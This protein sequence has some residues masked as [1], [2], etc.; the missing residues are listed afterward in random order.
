MHYFTSYNLEVYA[1]ADDVDN[2]RKSINTTDPI[3]YDMV[4]S[5]TA[6]MEGE[7]NKTIF[8]PEKRRENYDVINRE[9]F[10]ISLTWYNYEEDMERFSKE[11]PTYYF[12]LRGVGA[13]P[14]D[15][16]KLLAHNGDLTYFRTNVN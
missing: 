4:T 14:G 10:F 1:N 7:K 15:R 6:I 13:D 12:I 11:Y 16:W 8:P 3:C 9:V 2:K 5:L